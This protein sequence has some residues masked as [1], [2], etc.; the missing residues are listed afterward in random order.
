MS[1]VFLSY[2]R[3]DH[4]LVEQV[5]LGL[6][7]VGI[8]VW[9][10]QDMPGVDWQEELARE[11]NTMVAVVVVWTVNSSNSKYV[12]D[13]ARLGLHSDKLINL[14]LGVEEPPFP[15]DRVNGLT[16]EGWNG[17]E[18]HSGWTRLIKTIEALAVQAGVA[19]PGQM[20]EA[21][22]RNERELRTKKEELAQAQEAF[23]EAQSRTVE[24]DETAKFAGA[25]LA[26]AEEDLG[27]AGEMRLGAAILRAAQEELESARAANT[28]AFSALRA[29]KA[30]QSEA[31]RALSRATADLE[32]LYSEAIDPPSLPPVKAPPRTA[33]TVDRPPPEVDPVRVAE[34]ITPAKPPT[35]A[36]PIETPTLEAVP[37]REA[38][39]PVSSP[40]PDPAP[41]IPAS[42]PSAAAEPLS[43]A[44]GQSLAR[45]R[46][47]SAGRW[48]AVAG[49]LAVLLGGAALLF[50]RMSPSPAPVIVA[51]APSAPANLS[52]SRTVTIAAQPAAVEVP[53]AKLVG[54][55]ALEG[56]SCDNPVTFAEDNGGLTRTWA[57][58]T[59]PVTVVPGTQAG[60]VR[61]R[62]AD[63]STYDL[64]E[65]NAL[66]LI[67][68][69]GS[70]MGMTK[71][72]G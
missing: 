57:G 47:V 41:P 23:Q 29:A 68:P 33:P 49:V 1:G 10:D 43:I 58:K 25:T 17:R 15:F 64:D 65:H 63:G 44:P 60:A 36:A 56:L 32:R 5:M 54:R 52:A 69:G 21:L 70:P 18:P 42:E 22:T 11:L 3:G 8:E 67:P 72:A 40:A 55:W 62:A 24:A 26:R 71:C 19:Q 6:R 37:S 39:L 45:L 13:E 20:T 50:H 2:S 31:S 14:L 4:A 30:R 38:S 51:P 46:R 66:S 12:R 59:L 61:F 34:P 16:L 27:R 28:A 35:V 7:R 48:L 9:W 53:G